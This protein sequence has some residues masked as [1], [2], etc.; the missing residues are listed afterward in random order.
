LVCG[1][2]GELFGILLTYVIYFTLPYF[3]FVTVAVLLVYWR[4]RHDKKR[5]RTV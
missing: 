3:C 5:N 2:V 4:V 1:I